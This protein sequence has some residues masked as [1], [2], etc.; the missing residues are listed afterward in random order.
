[1]GIE[2]KSFQSFCFDINNCTIACLL[3]LHEISIFRLSIVTCQIEGLTKQIGGTSLEK[4]LFTK[5]LSIEQWV[6]H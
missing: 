3:F 4:P 5:E 2:S 6:L 1:M